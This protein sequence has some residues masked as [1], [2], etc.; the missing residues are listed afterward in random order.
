MK[1]QF[2]ALDLDGTVLKSDRTI[3]A[4][5][6]RTVQH[7]AQKIPVVIATGRHH[8]TARPYYHELGL[9]GPIICCNG[10]YV[11][12]YQQ[13]KVIQHNAIPKPLA[14]DFLRL[15]QDQNMAAVLYATHAMM[16]SVSHPIPYI[17][18]LADWAEQYPENVKPQVYKVADLQQELDANEYIWKFVL[19]GEGVAAFASQ[20]FIEEHFSAEQSW[21]DRFDFAYKGNTKGRALRSYLDS[22]GIDPI[23]MVAIGDHHNDISMLKLAGLGVAM[24]NAGSEIKAIA[25]RVAVGHNDEEQGLSSTLIEVFE[26]NEVYT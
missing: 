12:N 21:R 8:T 16:H 5:L 25:D 24:G 6:I 14:K 3:S 18:A 9:T 11:Y 23:H 4:D 7:L 26:L 2:L 1:Y 15:A 22:L 20:S 10:A 19:E 17:D 13:E